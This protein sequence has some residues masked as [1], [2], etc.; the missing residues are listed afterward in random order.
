M[1]QQVDLNSYS[2]RR[3]LGKRLLQRMRASRKGERF[4]YSAVAEQATP[5]RCHKCM[6][7]ATRVRVTETVR[8]IDKSSRVFCCEGCE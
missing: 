7:P 4:Q 1:N 6:K 3:A 2:Q 8:G 5:R